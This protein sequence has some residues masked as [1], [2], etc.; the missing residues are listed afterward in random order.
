[1]L[2]DDFD[3]VIGEASHRHHD[4]VLVLADLFDV[5]GGIARFRTLERMGKQ[6]GELVEPN[7]RP[8]QRGEIECRP[9]P[10]FSQALR[11]L[12]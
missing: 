4:A 5:V 6:A 8:E 11:G 3:I 10:A 2:L 12:S 9:S 7:G 1:V